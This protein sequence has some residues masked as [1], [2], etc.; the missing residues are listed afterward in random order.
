[1]TVGRLRLGLQLAGTGLDTGH[2][3]PPDQFEPGVEPAKQ[4]ASHSTTM[5][6]GDLTLDAELPLTK[7]LAPR[8]SLPLRAVRQQTEFHGATGAVLA[9]F[10]S[11]HHRQGTKVGLGDIGLGARWRLVESGPE[12]RWRIDAR[13]GFTL[14]TGGTEPN[15]DELGRAGKAHE[16][17]FF[18]SGTVD[19]TLAL[20]TE[21]EFGGWRLNAFAFG[22][23][24]LYANGHGYKQGARAGGGIGVDVGVGEAW[25]LL[26][27]PEV[28]H[29]QASA[30]GND[31]AEGSGRTDA[32]A[33]GGVV[34]VPAPAWTLNAFV[35]VP[36]HTWST[37]EQIEVP[38]LGMVGVTW[39]FDL[40]AVHP[41]SDDPGRAGTPRSPSTTRLAPAKPIHRLLDGTDG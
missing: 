28:Y 16:H 33:T 6:F 31:R 18:G 7:W 22:R 27:R 30:W 23:A 12:R 35:K 40:F 9:G 14:P 36:V 4:A 29:E 39:A 34:W 2:D 41:Q 8:L 15:P 20:D 1:M 11:I 10:E 13:P 37:G 24:S 25:R 17:V 19:P 5:A 32:I 26:A 21:V 3:V 38:L